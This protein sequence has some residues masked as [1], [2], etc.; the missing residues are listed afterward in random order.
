MKVTEG[1]AVFE[2]IAFVGTPGSKNQT[3][4]VKTTAINSLKVADIMKDQTKTYDDLIATFSVDFWE[5]V[6]GEELVDNQ[7]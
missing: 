4:F 7:C 2:N 3:F 6:E 5:C 1:E